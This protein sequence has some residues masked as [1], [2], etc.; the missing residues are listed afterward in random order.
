MTRF[1]SRVIVT[2]RA[3]LGESDCR[4]DFLSPLRGRL[5]AVAKGGLRSAR[6]FMGGFEPPQIMEAGFMTTGTADRILIEHAGIIEPFPAL[7]SGPLRLGRASVILE[8]ALLTVPMYQY[9]PGPYRLVE[10]GLSLLEKD[11]DSDR[12]PLLYSFRLLSLAGQAP[13]LK[14]C[15]GCGREAGKRAASFCPAEGGL[16][17]RGCRRKGVSEQ[18]IMTVSVDTRHTINTVLEA[19]EDRLPRF[20]FT[21]R[22]RVQAEQLLFVFAAHQ[23][24]SPLRSLEFMRNLKAGVA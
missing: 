6:R 10:T 18:D 16:V 1:N 4:V 20:D 17:C 7:R 22:S 8:T 15:V 19:R 13:E 24:G 2:G 5:S 21:R 12:W 14:R 9:S 3:P 11:P 23:L